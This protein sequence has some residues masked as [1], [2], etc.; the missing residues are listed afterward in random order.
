MRRRTYRPCLMRRLRGSREVKV[1][2]G[3]H[4]KNDELLL[5]EPSQWEVEWSRRHYQ[6]MK[7]GLEGKIDNR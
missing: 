6:S 1:N 7:E 4:E 5:P 3:S 2:N